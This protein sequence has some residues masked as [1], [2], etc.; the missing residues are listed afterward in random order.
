MKSLI[1]F[2]MLMS[3]TVMA[4]SA[5]I[6]VESASDA[7][8]NAI[9]EETSSL[10]EAASEFLGSMNNNENA[11]KL[12]SG[13]LSSFASGESMDAISSLKGLSKMDFSKDQLKS[14]GG[15]LAQAVPALLQSNFD[16]E[17]GELGQYIGK[18][19]E[20]FQSENF[21]SASSAISKALEYVDTDSLQSDLL[22]GIV[23]SYAPMLQGVDINQALDMGKSLL[24]G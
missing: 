8:D 20:F 2:F 4:T 6:N 18:A 12:V 24:G 14:Y 11:S 19:I 1:V 21:A 16:L 15:L 7:L 9:E 13:L 5:S 23:S 3:F 22:N 10:E 17:N